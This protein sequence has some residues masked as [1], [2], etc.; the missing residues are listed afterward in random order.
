[1]HETIMLAGRAIR[2]TKGV[3]FVVLRAANS[4]TYPTMREIYA[5]DKAGNNIGPTSGA[6][7]SAS[8]SASGSGY[9][10]QP[11]G[12][13]DGIEGTGGSGGNE[14]N[15]WSPA[16]ANKAS[17]ARTCWVQ[18]LFPQMFSIYHMD[19]VAQPSIGRY[20]IDLDIEYTDDG[21]NFYVAYALRN[22]AF[23]TAAPT[24]LF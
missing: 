16:N 4:N 15:W 14:S 10:Y 19:M 22:L 8:S 1:M 2:P 12:I 20:P 13:F 24:R 7:F 6:T 5:Y 21:T 9:A 23:T 3:R 18:A 17:T 11:S